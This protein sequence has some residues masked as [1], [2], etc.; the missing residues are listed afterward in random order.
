MQKGEKTLDIF[1]KIYQ[2]ERKN[3]ATK[4]FQF[5]EQDG[6]LRVSNPVYSEGMCK[7][8][9]YAYRPP[10]GIPFLEKSKKAEKR[11]KKFFKVMTK[12]RNFF[13][14]GFW[15]EWQKK[16][17]DKF[18]DKMLKKGINFE[19]Y[20]TRMLGMLVY[21]VPDGIKI[22]Q[23]YDAGLNI[24]K[25]LDAGLYS[26]YQKEVWIGMEKVPVAMCEDM[27][28]YTLKAL[29]NTRKD[30]QIDQKDFD[31]FF[32]LKGGFISGVTTIETLLCYGQISVTPKQIAEM[33][34]LTKRTYCSLNRFPTLQEMYNYCVETGKIQVEEQ[35]KY[36]TSRQLTGTKTAANNDIQEQIN[37]IFEAAQNAV[38]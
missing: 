14:T 22:H 5:V 31:K 12:K 36:T 6:R 7:P 29:I 34:D 37:D 16:R 25:A 18:F 38:E 11:A 20:D 13:A 1:K 33:Y 10:T 2:E 21:E 35:S 4:K 30:L 17:Y 24:A 9:S 19:Y 28:E 23:M 15:A 32:A 26:N 8:E 3:D 27:A